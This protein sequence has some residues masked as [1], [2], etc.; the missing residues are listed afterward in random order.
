MGWKGYYAIPQ[1][2]LVSSYDENMGQNRH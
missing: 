2:D 1:Q